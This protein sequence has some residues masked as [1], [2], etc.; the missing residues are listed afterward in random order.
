MRTCTRNKFLEPD[1]TRCEGLLDRFLDPVKDNGG[2][3]GDQ[4]GNRAGE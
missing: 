1:A 3:R 2:S 4:D